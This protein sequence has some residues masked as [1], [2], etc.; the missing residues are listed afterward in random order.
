MWPSKSQKRGL[1]YWWQVINWT[2]TAGIHTCCT[3]KV[4]CDLLDSC[5]NRWFTSSACLIII[6]LWSVNCS[7]ASH[8]S[9]L[10]M[11]TE[12]H[13]QVYRN[14]M[15]CINYKVGS[16]L[17]NGDKV[18]SG[19]RDLLCMSPG[20]RLLIIKL[21]PTESQCYKNQE[22]AVYVPHVY[23]SF[24]IPPTWYS[25]CSSNPIWH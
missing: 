8:L 9:E 14:F 20:W 19:T 11:V 18:E 2:E 22:Y 7:W 24:M 3:V 6:R 4:V 16:C 25:I 1:C 17:W 21:F 12:N 5:I 23:R 13:D 10:V 15:F